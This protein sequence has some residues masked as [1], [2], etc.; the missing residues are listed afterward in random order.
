MTSLSISWAGKHHHTAALDISSLTCIGLML[1]PCLM[2]NRADTMPALALSRLSGDSCH[3]DATRCTV[4]H[5]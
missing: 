5:A 4:I 1:Q 3:S 2:C